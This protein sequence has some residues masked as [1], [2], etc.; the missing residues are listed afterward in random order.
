MARGDNDVAAAIADRLV[1]MGPVRA[2]R[3]F[4]GHG[5]FL[6]GVMFGLVWRETVYFKV[7]DPNRA[8]YEKAGAK[9]F[10]Y[11]RGP[12]R[13]SM[14]YMTVPEK[15]LGDGATLA[16]WGERAL[17]VARAGKAKPRTRRRR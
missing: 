15:V 6:D 5:I 9:F 11:D 8:D 16:R 3:M 13:V 12:K 17:A 14:S 7:G 10:T 2:R 4:G 1:A